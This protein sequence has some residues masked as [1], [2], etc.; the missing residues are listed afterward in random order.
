MNIDL[1]FYWK[2]FLK[3]LP[4]MT[5]L[6]LICAGVALAL[7]YK[8]PTVYSTQATLLVEPPQIQGVSSTVETGA[9]V[10]L[11]VIQQRLMTRANLIDISN[12]RDVFETENELTPDQVVAL[13]N[14]N[15]FINR[16]SG[17]DRATLMT[18]GFKSSNAQT[19]ANVVNDYVTIVLKENV[20]LRTRIAEGNLTF[21]E[22]EVERIGKDID[23]QSDKILKFKA[24]NEGALPDSLEYR[25]NRVDLLQERIARLER[26]LSNLNEQKERIIQVYETTGRLQTAPVT[27]L[28]PAETRLATLEAE[29]ANARAIFSENSPKIELLKSQVAQQEAVVLREAGSTTPAEEG[30]SSQ[31]ALLQISVAQIDSQTESTKIE[32][33]NSVTELDALQ[34]SIIRTS[35]NQ[36]ALAG[37]ERDYTN[38]QGQYNAAI[39]RLNGARIEE[40]I[41][42]SSRGQRITVIENANVPTVPSSPN[43]KLIVAAG[44]GAGLGAMA[45]LFI[46]LELL[47]KTIRRPAELVSA[48]GV[49]PI[50]AI[51]YMESAGRKWMRRGLLVTSFLTVLIGVPLGLWMIDQYYYPLDEIAQN[52]IDRFF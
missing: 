21:F 35:P 43:R 32:L 6:F 46:L 23:A 27:Q 13:M 1:K 44:I 39:S 29:L 37:L 42:V 20:R 52:V 30:V 40:R 49:M 41:E 47:N 51:P 38:L 22:Q 18:I 50:A 9:G 48:L 5:A 34:E 25:R 8:L 24:E 19:A 36:I 2:L 28:S 15:T 31:D 26:E 11:E 17:Q 45:G 12:S 4:A 10:Q 33:A 3:R 7:A 16:S 14:A